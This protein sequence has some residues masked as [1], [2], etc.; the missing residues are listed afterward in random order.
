[1]AG[2]ARIGEVEDKIRAGAKFYMTGKDP[3][4]LD[5]E[6]FYYRYFFSRYPVVYDRDGILIFRVSPG[7]TPGP[8]PLRDSPPPRG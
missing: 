7:A 4:F 2:E 8:L 6:S 5:K 3:Q 1:M